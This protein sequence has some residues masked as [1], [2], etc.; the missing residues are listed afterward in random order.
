M[1]EGFEEFTYEVT[2]AEMKIILILVERFKKRIGKQLAVKNATI[3][4]WLFD[5]HGIQVGGARIRK[6]INYIRTENLVPNLIATSK[7]YYI[8]N[9]GAELEKYILS[10]RQRARAIEA[11]ANKIET[12]HYNFSLK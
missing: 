3:I 11:I 7:G 8:S 9:D 6:M 10:L 4:K 12:H 2:E 1:I 5:N